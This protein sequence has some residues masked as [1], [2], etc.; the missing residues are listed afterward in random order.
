MAID[1]NDP[2]T[3]DVDDKE[4]AELAKAG[5][6]ETAV[7]AETDA[8]TAPDEVPVEVAKPEPE[9]AAILAADGKN[10]I[11]YSVLKDTREDARAAKAELARLQRE[12]QELKAQPVVTAPVVPKTA[13]LT[14]PEDVQ[15]RLKKIKED[16]GDDIAAQAER[17]YWL[18]QRTLQQ[19]QTIDQLAQ[20]IQNQHQQNQRT[21]TEQIE[22]AIAAS[23]KLDA[24]A[25]AEDQTWF[26][27][28]TELHQTLTKVDRNYAAASWFDKM[29]MLPDK[30]EALFGQSFEKVDTGSARAKVKAALDAPP[31]SLSELSGGTPP[32]RSEVQKLED[33]EGNHLTAFFA[34]LAQDPRKFESYIRSIS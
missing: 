3:W 4:L 34:K 24:W 20:Y 19:Q 18:E 9:P 8:K 7:E 12:L 17:T 22:D 2:T 13:P 14:L 30:V 28:A 23:P 10:T 31:N 29:R 21:E 6:I 5:A 1:L 25:K 11:P 16:W 15:Q 33:L 26:D 27:R 32:E